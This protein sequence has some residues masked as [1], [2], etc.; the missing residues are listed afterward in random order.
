MEIFRRGRDKATRLVRQWFVW[1]EMDKPGHVRKYLWIGTERKLSEL[2][3]WYQLNK[4]KYE[5]YEI[6]RVFQTCKISRCVSLH[7]DGDE[8][9]LTEAWNSFESIYSHDYYKYRRTMEEDANNK[10]LVN[11]VFHDYEKLLREECDCT[12][13]IIPG[14][15]VIQVLPTTRS[16]IISMFVFVTFTRKLS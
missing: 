4:K 5:R 1:T 12:K 13:R 7:L 10:D 9:I 8:K 6:F 14:G 11:S 16:F 3:K 2:V 15:Y